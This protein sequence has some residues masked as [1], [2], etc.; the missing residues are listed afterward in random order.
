[1]LIILN[2][3]AFFYFLAF[4]YYDFMPHAVK[5]ANKDTFI[6]QIA[7]VAGLKTLYARFK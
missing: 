4:Q 1:V 3:R 2:K 6:D 7:E 5:Y